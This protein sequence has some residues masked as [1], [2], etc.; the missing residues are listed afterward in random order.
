V[1]L[2]QAYLTQTSRPPQ[3]ALALGGK[4]RPRFSPTGKA[5]IAARRAPA[6]PGLPTLHNPNPPRLTDPFRPPE[7]KRLTALAESGAVADRP[8]VPG[9]GSAGSGGPLSLLAHADN[10][11][12]AGI[13]LDI[14]PGSR[15]GG[16]VAWRGFDDK[17]R[18]M[19]LGGLIFEPGAARPRLV[20]DLHADVGADLDQGAPVVGGGLR[21]V[22]TI[23]GPLGVALDGGAYLVIDGI[24]D[25][26][27]RLMGSTALV[28]RW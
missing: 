15:Y 28:V 20:V 19:L 14:E 9:T 23:W 21:T 17:A 12:R 7:P 3:G 27:L 13:A 26:R 10:R 11:L 1:S 22:L 18:G 4:A 6:L 25:T 5:A 24:E 16:I 8:G 2:A